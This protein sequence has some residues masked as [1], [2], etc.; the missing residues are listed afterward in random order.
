MTDEWMKRL[1]EALC[2][3]IENTGASCPFMKTK[4][5]DAFWCGVERMKAIILDVL[6]SDSPAIIERHYRAATKAETCPDCEFES[7]VHV[8]HDHF[9]ETIECGEGNHKYL[10][11]LNV[12]GNLRQL[13]VE[14]LKWDGGEGSRA[15][16]AKKYRTLREALKRLSQSEGHSPAPANKSMCTAD[17]GKKVTDNL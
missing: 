16:D 8:A 12:P 11:C 7:A 3:R 2:E 14:F 1:T 9:P 13:V 4:Q 6:K 5:Y 15:Y 17:I 10:L